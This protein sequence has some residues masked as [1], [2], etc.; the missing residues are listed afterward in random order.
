MKTST[1]AHSKLTL[2]ASVQIH[3]LL[4]VAQDTGLLARL[5]STR[6]ALWPSRLGVYGSISF[7]LEL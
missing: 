7:Q 2:S 5:R 6:Y 4:S 1:F 3:R